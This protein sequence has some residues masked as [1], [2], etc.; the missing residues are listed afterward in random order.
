M[1]APTATKIS[2]MPCDT[3]ASDSTTAMRTRK[4]P[5]RRPLASSPKPTTAS[6]S[7]IEN[8]YSPAI[9]DFTLPP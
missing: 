7:A 6:V 4:R 2:T 1:M 5:V 8:E 3:A 9:V